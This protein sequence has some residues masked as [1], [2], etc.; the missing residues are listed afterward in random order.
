MDIGEVE[1]LKKLT[2]APIA[3]MGDEVDFGE[4]GRGDIPV[5][6]ADGDVVLEQGAGLGAAVEA[7]ADLPFASLQAAVHGAGTD[8]AHLPLQSR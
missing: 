1:G 5:L 6:G 2:I 3:G 7:A 8:P 4:A